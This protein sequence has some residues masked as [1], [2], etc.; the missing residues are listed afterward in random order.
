M[1]PAD[2]ELAAALKTVPISPPRVPVFSN[3]TAQSEKDPE[4]I[5]TLL[6]QQVVK[7]VL[8]AQISS[9]LPIDAIA[10]VWE[11]GPGGVI[12]GLLKKGG[13]DLQLSPV[14]GWADVLAAAGKGA[15]A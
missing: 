7:P 13:F 3:V 12:C 2:E 8:W 6:A 5:R 14:A 9:R 10:K 11:P 1:K 15:A 4:R